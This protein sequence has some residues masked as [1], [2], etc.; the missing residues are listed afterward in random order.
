MVLGPVTS[1]KERVRDFMTDE[2]TSLSPDLTVE[3]AIERVTNE[4]HVGL[5]V[6]QDRQLV[7]FL[8]PK[9]LLRHIDEMDQTIG[10]IIAPGTVVAHPD[11]SL[12]DVARILFRMGV[13]ELPVVD[14]KGKMV[15]VVSTTD[16][17]RGHIERVTPSKMKKLQTTLEGLYDVE[18]DSVQ[19]PVE[20]EGLLPTQKRIYGDELEGRRLELMRGL[21]EPILVIEKE[22]QSILVDGHHRVIA[23]RQMGKSSLD[24][25]VLQL[26]RDIELGLERNARAAGLEE[27]DDVQILEE[28]QH[29]LVEV[30]TRFITED[31]QRR[32]QAAFLSE[33]VDKD[34][35]PDALP[36]LEEGEEL[37]AKPV[38]DEDE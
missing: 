31:W 26:D 21:A 11:M 37:P 6:A 25:Y 33:V 13:K 19:K 7:G 8:T 18:I 5:P 35:A 28:G 23:A 9:E 16:V 34:D 2:V 10:E 12:D 36:G 17:I 3:E 32:R 27:L 20:I 4:G 14:D 24:A 38:D 15:G 30:T 1:E 29:P 22:P